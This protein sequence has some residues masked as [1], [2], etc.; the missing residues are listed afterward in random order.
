MLK[1]GLNFKHSGLFGPGAVVREKHRAETSSV[2]HA[3][4]LISD[5]IDK[6]K[7]EQNEAIKQVIRELL[8]YSPRE[9]QL[10]APRQLVYLRKDLFLI[11]KTSFGKSMILQTVSLLLAKSITLVELQKP[12]SESKLRVLMTTKALALDVDLPDI[13]TVVIY[14]LPKN[15]HPVTVWQRGGRACRSGQRAAL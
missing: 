11:A 15:L 8:P 7:D 12:G 9:G 13:E 10:Q 5:G 3:Q 14:G 4:K 6:S 2:L 1:S